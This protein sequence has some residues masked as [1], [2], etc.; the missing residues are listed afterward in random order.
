MAKQSD[1]ITK[2]NIGSQ[3]PGVNHAGDMLVGR[4]RFIDLDAN[5]AKLRAIYTL[6]FISVPIFIGVTTVLASSLF[7]GLE[8]STFGILCA[9]NVLNGLETHHLVSSDPKCR[10]TGHANIQ[11]FWRHLIFICQPLH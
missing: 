8:Q 5:S 6:V 3:N 9:Y 2:D 10:V 4:K 11:V 1:E 7:S